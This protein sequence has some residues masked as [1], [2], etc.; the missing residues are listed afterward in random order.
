MFYSTQNTDVIVNFP[1]EMRTDYSLGYGSLSDWR[2]TSH[3][4]EGTPSGI[5]LDT[6]KCLTA[7]DVR[8]TSST[9]IGSAGDYALF[10]SNASGSKLTFDSEL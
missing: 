7:A 2:L 9:A 8:V 4:A 1:T 3:T 6:S 10:L 5:N